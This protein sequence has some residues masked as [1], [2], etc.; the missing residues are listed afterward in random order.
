PMTGAALSTDGGIVFGG[1]ADR[2]FFALH[3]ETGELL[4]QT[5][6]NGDISGAPIT[7]TVNGKQYVAVAAGG[8]IAMTTTLGRLVNV[9]VPQGTGVIW[10]FALPD[11]EPLQVPRPVRLDMPERSVLDGVYRQTQADQG[12]QIF[13]QECLSCHEVANYIGDNLLAKWGGGTLSDIYQDIALTM[14]PANPSGLTPVSYASIVAYFLSE[15]GYPSSNATL[16]GD[17]FQ[18]GSITIDSSGD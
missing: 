4:W 17:R 5:R 6:L 8:R 14:P 15:S 2:Q 3:D 16:P 1:T 10:V 12:E 11:D 18:L 9:D 7:Y 13:N